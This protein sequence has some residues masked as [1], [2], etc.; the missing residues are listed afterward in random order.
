MRRILVAIVVI[1][2]V[3]GAAVY[4]AD[5][6]G[7]VTVVWQ[8]W[9]ID[10]SVAVLVLGA[11]SIVFVVGWSVA[12]L[13][14]LAVAPRAFLRARR[15]RR[16]R[17]GYR[18]LT[19]GLAAVAAGDPDEAERCARR[20]DAL[21]DEPPLTRL[22]AAQAAQLKG[23][24]TAARS[25][26]TA[27]LAEP[28][29][30]FLGLRGL[31]VQALARGEDGV[32][33]KLAERARELRPRTGWVQRA[34]VELEARAGRW[35]RAEV[36]LAE[37]TR[38]GAIAPDESRHHRA[39]ILYERGRGAQAAGRDGEA[40]KLAGQ[41]HAADPAFAPATAWYARL[42]AADGSTRR[43]RKAIEA[44]WRVA[45]HPLLTAAYGALYDDE[46]PLAR[47]KRF[48][49]L[50]GLKPD[51]VEG[52][53]ALAE[54]AIEARLWG[55]ARRHLTEAGIDRDDAAPRLYRL[56]AKLEEAERTDGGR[57]RNW[58]ERAA[59]AT[60]PDPAYAC[61]ACGFI[62]DAW[63][64][65]CPRCRSFDQLVWRLRPGRGEGGMPTAS[66]APLAAGAPIDAPPRAVV[67][68]SALPSLDADVAQR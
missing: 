22:L 67:G 36:R 33:L 42:L 15:E 19:Y 39:A 10:T 14:R 66:I 9:R 38:R 54:A 55:E 20:A 48:E 29:T 59:R 60:A 4:F 8:G 61:N 17:E 1:A 45:P 64:P 52:R 30:E 2:V 16:R 12:V 7:A 63:T 46:P 40:L 68:S 56:M 23:D 50:Q 57:G 37:A 47:I 26:F 31:I 43:A 24:V 44:G 51:H 28:E 35:E 3:V 62:A 58:L 18:A 27:M 32:A 53:V 5:R 13:R 34:L 41:A 25:Y 6:P 11:A 21:L 49:R 65:L